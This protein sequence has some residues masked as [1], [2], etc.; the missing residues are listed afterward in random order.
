MFARKFA[1]DDGKGPAVE[2]AYE[3]VVEQHGN[4][5]AKSVKALCWFLNWGSIG[6]NTLNATLFE[7]RRGPCVGVW[8]LPPCSHG[9]PV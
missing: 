5:S 7:G 3:A 2:K 8:G 1:E 6:G 4:A 9:L